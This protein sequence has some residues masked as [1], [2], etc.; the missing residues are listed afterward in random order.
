MSVYAF[1][2]PEPKLMQNTPNPF[3][4]NTKIGYYLPT[5][6]REATIRVYDMNGA[7]IAVYP[8]V[9]FG[10]GELTINGG[11]F[12]AGMYLYSLIAD[13][14]LVDTKQMILTK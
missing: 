1:R 8:I 3:S 5:D 11:T 10:Q 9:S 7:E 6:T 2:Q 12:R 4:Q 14:Q 13:G